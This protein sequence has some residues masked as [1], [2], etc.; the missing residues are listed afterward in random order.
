M[1]FLCCINSCCP[2]IQKHNAILHNL[3]QQTANDV[4]TFWWHNA[5]K[6][7]LHMFKVFETLIVIFYYFFPSFC[8]RNK[9]QTH[10]KKTSININI[11]SRKRECVR[12]ERMYNIFRKQPY[13]MIPSYSHIK[14]RKSNNIYNLNQTPINRL[15]FFYVTYKHDTS[16]MCVRLCN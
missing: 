8:N 14:Y 11:K 1:S 13:L 16:F 2:V 5:K 4:S 7:N 10:I 9:S 3:W 12:E 6:N 15:Q